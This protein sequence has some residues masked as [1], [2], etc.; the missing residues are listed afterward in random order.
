MDVILTDKSSFPRASKGLK[1]NSYSQPDSCVSPTNKYGLGVNHTSFRNPMTS[2]GHRRAVQLLPLQSLVN[3]VETPKR[4]VSS[5]ADL[6]SNCYPTLNSDRTE[7][8]TFKA[9][10]SQPKITSNANLPSVF[11]SEK[12]QPIKIKKLV[13]KQK[14]GDLT[15]D[16]EYNPGKVFNVNQIDRVAKPFLSPQRVIS[17]NKSVQN[18]YFVSKQ[19]SQTPSSRGEEPGR[20]LNTRESARRTQFENTP[21]MRSEEEGGASSGNGVVSSTK[22]QIVVL[23]KF[24]SKSPDS[25]VPVI[26]N[27]HV[28]FSNALKF[29]DQFAAGKVKTKIS[30]NEMVTLKKVKSTQSNGVLKRMLHVP[31]MNV[32][33]LQEEPISAHDNLKEWVNGWK[34]AFNKKENKDLQKILTCFWNAPEGCVSILKEAASLGSL[35]EVLEYHSALPESCLRQ[36]AIGVLRGLDDVHSSL[37]RAYGA[38]TPSEIIFDA[39]YQPKLTP[40]ILSHSASSKLGGSPAN[41]KK[42]SD[43][44]ESSGRIVGLNRPSSIDEHAKAINL[45]LNNLHDKNQTFSSDIFD[46]GHLLLTCA[47]GNLEF[48]DPSGF[49]SL[50]NL[51]SLKDLVPSYRRHTKNFCCVLHNEEELR[52]WFCE[53]SPTRKLRETGQ[54]APLTNNFA[55]KSP[56]NQDSNS[57]SSKRTPSPVSLLDLL[58]RNNRFSDSFIDFL[59]NCLQIESNSKPST[60]SLLDHEFLSETHTSHGPILSLSE[61]LSTSRKH[62]ENKQSNS[63]NE[64]QLTRVTDAMKIVLMNREIKEKLAKYSHNE[65]YENKASREYQKLT[66]LAT[67]LGVPLSSLIDKFRNDL[68]VN[69]RRC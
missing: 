26:K 50:E 53:L 17:S 5:Q 7:E 64:E 44:E 3:N 28:N 34:K 4:V 11:T 67:E 45:G 10:K 2:R 32:Y 24:L 36:L 46:L 37:N 49:Y 51:K 48:F 9:L 58:R 21:A 30:L 54:K 56:K 59:C 62:Q 19:S 52:R 47:L 39:N 14:G 15:I 57:S 33:D 55:L 12:P 16:E 69:D 6:N 66:T 43:R 42:E 68:F 27:K 1:D 60:K 63:I 8:P 61:L 41:S 20:V 65:L 25:N 23:K 22:K 18:L 31:T 29:F 35:Q 40:G 38:L 13:A